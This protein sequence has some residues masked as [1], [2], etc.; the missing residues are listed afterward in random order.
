MC[1]PGGNVGSALPADTAFNAAGVDRR[2]RR[3][4]FVLFSVVVRV[5]CLPAVVRLP[6]ELVAGAMDREDVLGFVGGTLDLL[7]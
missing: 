2:F 3:A 6:D 5:D 7:P 1:G 4:A